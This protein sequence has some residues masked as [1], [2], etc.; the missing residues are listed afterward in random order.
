[1]PWSFADKSSTRTLGPQAGRVVTSLYERRRPIFSLRDV[2]DITGASVRA[3]QSITARLVRNG[4]AT[5]LKPGL[6]ILI[7]FELGSERQYLGNPYL[8]ARELVRP[9]R[10]YLS[11]ASAMD[12]HGMT[13]QP[14]L[15][16]FITTTKSHR[17]RTILGT[18]FRFVRCQVRHFFG[19]ADSWVDKTEQVAVSDP[20]R[21]IIDGLREPAYCGGLTEVTKG[22][23]IK[24]NLVNIQTL[25]SYALRMNVVAVMARLGFLVETLG[26]MA[27]FELDQLR[28]RLTKSY[29]LLDPSLPKEG[30]YLARWRLQLN[31]NPDEL[32]AVRGT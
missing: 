16:V 2:R 26:I 5:R 31:V 8:V 20:E 27:P 17:P 9:E 22:F 7:P 28:S 10:Y 23:W 32:L 30:R 18:E 1:M 24:R 15:V 3:A 14:Q 21:T 25:V 4:I 6:F 11:H 13:T 12:I 19:V 29:H